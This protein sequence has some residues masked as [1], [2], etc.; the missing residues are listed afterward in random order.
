M[1]VGY[2]WSTGVEEVRVRAITVGYMWPLEGVCQTESSLQLKE[3][4]VSPL[5]TSIPTSIVWTFGH[6]SNKLQ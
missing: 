6:I 4:I 1:V 5:P 3:C 2:W